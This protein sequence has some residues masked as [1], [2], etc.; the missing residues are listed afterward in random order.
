M[1]PTKTANGLNQKAQKI[2]PNRI[3]R[4]PRADLSNPCSVRTGSGLATFFWKQSMS[5]KIDPEKYGTATEIYE[6]TG[7][8]R[9]TLLSAVDRNEINHRRTL[10][11]TLLI[12][13][14]SV[15]D[16]AKVDRKLGRPKKSHS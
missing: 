11:G 5:D 8:A 3:L 13:L 4:Q 16:W 14:A 9:T 12:E 7:I 15:K 2:W 6:K 10:G 1:W